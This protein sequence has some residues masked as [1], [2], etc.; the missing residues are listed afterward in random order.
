[1][2]KQQLYNINQI[3]IDKGQT[4]FKKHFP[5]YIQGL[6]LFL[7]GYFI[8]FIIVWNLFNALVCFVGLNLLVILNQIYKEVKD[9]GGAICD[10]KGNERDE[11]VG[12]DA[13]LSTLPVEK[14]E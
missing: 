5:K 7:V 14:T 2:D 3:G 13:T 9:N 11:E 8:Y 6:A 4:M 12:G 10:D 1:M